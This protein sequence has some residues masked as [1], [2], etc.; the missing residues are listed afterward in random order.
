MCGART[1][2]DG[3]MLNTLVESILYLLQIDPAARMQVA[4]VFMHTI[5][6]SLCTVV[7]K[8]CALLHVICTVWH[9]VV[10]R[11]KAD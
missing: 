10:T 3:H 4:Y 8:T 1:I 7:C 5:S 11:F 2:I 6:K 9:A